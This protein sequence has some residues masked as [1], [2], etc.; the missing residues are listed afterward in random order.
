MH[1]MFIRLIQTKECDF[2]VPEDKYTEIYVEL[3]KK[4]G[5]QR[6]KIMKLQQNLSK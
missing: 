4:I 2:E 1:H 3:L 6:V 5:K